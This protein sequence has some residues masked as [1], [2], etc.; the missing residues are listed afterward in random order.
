MRNALRKGSTR[1]Y[2]RR[3]TLRLNFLTYLSSGYSNARSTWPGT[4]LCCSKVQPSNGRVLASGTW[5]FSKRVQWAIRRLMF[6]STE[7]C[8]FPST[9]D[10][11][12]SVTLCRPITLSLSVFLAL[13]ILLSSLSPFLSVSVHLFLQSVGAYCSFLQNENLSTSCSHCAVMA[14]AAHTQAKR[15][16]CADC[17]CVCKR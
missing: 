7:R 17:V 15:C 16:I 13:D 11:R 1:I 8:H 14:A 9:L 4:G 3:H 2:V 10:T 12:V 6:P 5:T